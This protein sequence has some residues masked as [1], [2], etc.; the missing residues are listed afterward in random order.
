[1]SIQEGDLKTDGHFLPRD[2]V[3]LLQQVCFESFNLE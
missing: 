1:M 2:Q 3:P